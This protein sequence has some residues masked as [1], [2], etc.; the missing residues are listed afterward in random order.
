MNAR[1]SEQLT[2]TEFDAHVNKKTLRLAFIGMSNCGK[3]YRS[4]VLANELSFQWYQVDAEI[5]RTLGLENIEKMAQ[6]L[7]YP[8]TDGYGEREER[9]LELED[10]FTKE[11]AQKS[12]GKNL[13]FDTT[14]SVIYVRPKTMCLLQENCLVVNIDVGDDALD[15]MM[16]KFFAHP[17]PLVW[18]GYFT[19][20]PGESEMDA[21]RRGY[22]QL[23]KDRLKHYRQIAHVTISL[24]D[25]YDTSAEETLMAIRD[26]L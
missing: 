1:T 15:K 4:R 2:P 11:A 20:E 18:S 24:S 25:V 21:M 7:S 17:K 9:Y 19:Q 10:T 3:T 14:G 13:V 8:S 12:D 16:E 23:L 5:Q 22:P 6:W 26:A